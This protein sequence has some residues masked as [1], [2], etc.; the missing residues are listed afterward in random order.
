MPFLLILLAACNNTESTLQPRKIMR[1]DIAA[2]QPDIE[3]TENEQAAFQAWLEVIKGEYSKEEYANSLAVTA[4][5][6]LVLQ[7]L[8][9]LDSVEAVIT[10]ILPSDITPVGVISPYNQMVITH[11]NGFL[12]IALNHYLGADN[13]VYAGRFPEHERRQKEISRMPIDITIALHASNHPD[14]L[15]VNSSLLNHLLYQGALLESALESL[16]EETSEAAVLGMTMQE[17]E[18]CVENEANI[19]QSLI[20]QQ[21]LYSTDQQMIKRLLAPAPGS[22][23]ISSNAPGQT[24]LFTALKITQ[25]YLKNNDIN[26]AKSLLN[27]SYYNS[28]KSL[29]HSKYSP[30]YARK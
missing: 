29:I 1:L 27:T 11:P 19:W 22:P 26:S 9:P 13:Q 12:F 17:Y 25:S 10:T 16:P 24:A 4:F 23:S 8:P 18:W 20:S 30:I 28:D 15:S 5:E 6:P 2:S 7:F 14:S 3:F 21:L